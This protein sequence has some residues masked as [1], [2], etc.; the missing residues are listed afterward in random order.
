M[1]V[2]NR[3]DQTRIPFEGYADGPSVLQIYKEALVRYSDVFDSVLRVKDRSA[4]M[5]W[6]NG[7]IGYIALRSNSAVPPQIGSFPRFPMRS[8]R[9]SDHEARRDAEKIPRRHL[10]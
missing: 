10:E 1:T 9:R 3:V 6:T 8:P 5:V 7:P 2:S 4:S